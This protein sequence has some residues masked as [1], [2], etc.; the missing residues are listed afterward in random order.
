MSSANRPSRGVTRRS[1]MATAAGTVALPYVASAQP[2]K[3]IKMGAP[4][5][6]TGRFSRMAIYCID[7]YRLWA[8]HINEMGY[9]YGNEHLP[10]HGPGLIQGRK[11]ELTILDDTS[12]PTTGA[13][14][15]TYLIY[16]T[17]VDLLLSAYASSINMATRPII[18]G[19]QIPTVS[20][21]A[22]SNDIWIGQHLKW[23]VQLMTPAARR[24]AGIEAAC[25]SA[26]LSKIALLYI[27]DAMP[28]AAAAGV[29]KRLVDAGLDVVLYEAYPIGMKDMVSLVRK[30]RDAGAEVLAGGGY[31][32]DAILMAKAALSLKWT[33]KAIW[34]MADFG[35][36]DF[37]KALGENAAWH[38]GDTEWLATATWPGNKQFV[39]AFRKEYGKEPEWVAA[40]GYG[41]CQILE[42]AVKR[43]GS[44]EDHKGIRD[45]LFSLERDT[46]FAHYKVNPLGSPDA[47]LQVGATRIGMQYQ[48]ENGQ[49]VNKVIYPKSI[50]NGSFHLFKWEN[51]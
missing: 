44:V 12:D 41:A 38:C 15:M 27:D 36:P 19:A 16:N 5:P 37:K 31:T 34:H 43:V 50:A 4:M 17:K 40:A 42:E 33:P 7:G 47:G 46:V 28:I 21:S 10:H 20:S 35:Y 24:F 8:K 2:A 13:R 3:P 51:L 32:E 1:F 18:E 23:M 45:V 9:S 26:G 39:E 6:L 30:A 14:L 49:L 29:R 11:V 48:M 25:K 22:S